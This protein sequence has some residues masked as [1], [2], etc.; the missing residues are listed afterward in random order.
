MASVEAA[1]PTRMSDGPHG[2][3]GMASVEAALEWFAH[4]ERYCGLAAK[5]A[6]E[7]AQK[8]RR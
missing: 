7:L 3:P 1:L 4:P 2:E 5:K 8:Y 6:H